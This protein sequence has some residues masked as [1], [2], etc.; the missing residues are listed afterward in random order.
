MAD[1]CREATSTLHRQRT[2]TPVT[3]PYNDNVEPE[4]TD[5]PGREHD[6]VEYRFRDSALAV[7]RRIG[8]DA[9]YQ[10]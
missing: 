8:H 7:S 1:D 9:R 3:C 2:D 10:S 6:S 5:C 4:G